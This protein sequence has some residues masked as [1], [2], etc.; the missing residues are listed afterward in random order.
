MHGSSLLE[1]TDENYYSILILRINAKK[2]VLVNYF[3]ALM[4]RFI[5]LLTI[6]IL[7]SEI[8]QLSIEQCILFSIINIM[9]KTFF[10]ALRINGFIKKRNNFI[11]LLAP[12]FIICLVISFCLPIFG[13]QITN[14]IFRILF[15]FVCILGIYGFIKLIKFD[16]YYKMYKMF[17]NP[18]SNEIRNTN[19]SF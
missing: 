6:L 3:W 5:S 19:E 2:Y 1:N 10:N 15:I 18:E 14:N 4:K 16:D 8:T 12:I 9:L 17:L 7:T 13:L 11:K